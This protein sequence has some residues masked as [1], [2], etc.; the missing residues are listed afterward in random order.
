MRNIF[1]QLHGEP[2]SFE[3]T[4]CLFEDGSVGS[5]RLAAATVDEMDAWLVA[6]RFAMKRHE[7]PDLAVE[8]VAEEYLDESRNAASTDS[9]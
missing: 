3:L 6:L 4:N 7:A 5:L 2:F 9:L 8:S 1:S